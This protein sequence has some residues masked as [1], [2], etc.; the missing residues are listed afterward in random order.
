MDNRAASTRLA[1]APTPGRAAAGDASLRRRSLP[2]LN[3][4]D[5]GREERFDRITELART[6]FGVPIAA[7]TLLDQDYSW[8]KSCVGADVT[9][10]PR[11]ESFCD[12]AV[13]TGRITV[14]E[15]ALL[16]PRFSHLPTVTGEPN[17]RF[18]AGFPVR[19]HHGVTFGTLCLY[20]VEPRSLDEHQLTV[21]TQLATW[22]ESELLTSREVAHARSVQQGLLPREVP[23]VSGYSAAAVC[24][25]AAAVAGDFYDHLPVG[26]RHAFVVA[27]VMGKGMGA[28]ILMSN[29]RSVLRAELRSLAS[30]RYDA[31][32]RR[33]SV[34]DVVRAVNEAVLDD[35]GSS[36][37][38][39]TA[40][41]GWADPVTGR[42][43]YVDAG[44]GLTV[45]LRADGTTERLASEEVPLGILDTYPWQAGTVH[46]EPGDTIVCFSDGLLEL[47]DV[48]ADPDDIAPLVALA[49]GA[50]SPRSLIAE[51]RSLGSSAPLADDVTVLAIRRD[52]RP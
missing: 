5:T 25:P 34:A 31:A 38:F 35:L 6:I 48:H 21:A 7:V 39:V 30:G 11:S 43:D 3:I 42:I 47:V 12:V 29:V 18:Y 32:E 26:E 52:P 24:L 49:A 33:G 8:F 22:V 2:A 9:V 44:H 36:Q 17:L 20:D 10:N 1:A 50:G 14:V 45:V 4:L 40:F 15:D 16:D 28:A 51:V 23:D 19:D 37:A 13:T 46:L 41:V 27:D